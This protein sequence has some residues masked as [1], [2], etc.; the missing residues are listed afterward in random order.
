MNQTTYS[1]T[2]EFDKLNPAQKQAV[3]TI[4]GAVLVIAGPGTGKTQILAARIANILHDEK[5]QAKPENILC[6]TFTDAGVVAMRNRL[7]KFIGSEAH[8]V[9]IHTFHSFCNRVIQENSEYFGVKDVEPIMELDQ[10]KLLEELVDGFDK[11]HPLK[12]WRGDIYYDVKAGRLQKLFSLMRKENLSPEKIEAS[13]NEFIEDIPNKEEFLY[14][15]KTG[16]FEKGDVNP[17]KAEEIIQ[18]LRSTVAAAKELTNYQELKKKKGYYDFDDMIYWVLESFKS[19]EELLMSYQERFQY[20]LVD[21]YQD[22]NGAQN[23]IFKLLI[24]FWENPNAFVVGDDDQSIYRFQGANLGNIVDFYDSFIVKA[25]P[26][27][28]E[29]KKRVIV[30]SNNYRSTQAVLDL[31]KASIEHNNERL[32]H[33]LKELVLDKNLRASL[34]DRIKSKVQP[35]L[36]QYYNHTHELSDIAKQIETLHKEGA[37]LNEIAVIYR[38]HKQSEELLTFLNQKDIAVRTKRKLNILDLPLTS[39]LLEIMRY[40]AEESR[41]PHSR[42]DLLFQMFHFD[43]FELHSLQVARLAFELRENRYKNPK[44]TWRE[45]LHNGITVLDQ[46]SLDKLHRW[47]KVIEKWQSDLQNLPLQLFFQT[48]IDDLDLLPYIMQ[49][50]EKIWLLQELKTLFDF[51]KGQNNMYPKLKAIEFLDTIKTMQDYGISIDFV[52][53]T[54]A[55]NAVNFTT[56]HGSKGLEFKHVFLLGMNKKVWDS[57]LRNR[58]FKLPDGLLQDVSEDS[59]TEETRRLFYVAMTRAEEHLQISYAQSSDEGKDLS[60]SRYVSELIDSG[61][62]K[63]EE[64]HIGDKEIT[65]FTLNQIRLPLPLN[66]P[67]LEKA[68]FKERLEQ[69]SMS[70]THLNNYLK[71]PLK[72]YYTN[73]LQVPSAKNEHMA[74]GSAIHNA[75]EEMY[76]MM[77]ENDGVFPPVDTLIDLAERKLYGQEDSFTEKQ[78]GQKKDYIKEFLPKY[79]ATYIDTWNKNVKLEKRLYGTFNSIELNGALDKIEFSDNQVTIIDYK[80]GQFKNSVKKFGPP[81]VDLKEGVKLTY[82][83]EFGGDYWRQAVFYKILIDHNKDIGQ[84]HWEYDKTEFD[85]VEPDASTGKFN[86]QKV[87][88]AETDI[89]IVKDQIQQTFNNIQELKFDGCGEDDCEW[90]NL[91][92]ES[93]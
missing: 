16:K 44:I 79:Y 61:L 30:M 25:F 28:N 53:S 36:V 26:D 33:Q 63:L 70:V 17:R 93:K 77:L 4:D 86:K 21:E 42:E 51:I 59:D 1:F 9:N 75:L 15:R 50:E 80:T 19:K 38:I 78:Y 91:V 13:V 62:I 60:P 89:Q 7:I 65:E 27:I 73:F 3:E 45:V 5:T 6:L 41:I 18:R 84:Q 66:V 49:H 34:T 37:D 43:F 32:I 12:R 67:L 92:D 40:V 39:Q 55:E 11:N 88:V 58:D 64:E 87:V 52:K 56:A 68:Y 48:I 2:D 29:R 35:K 85:F 47:S 46:E 14:K 24:S 22:T 72:F 57:A 8:K 20:V 10:I 83:K 74:F 23:E 69:Y 76:K 71:C 31:S 90:C 81:A 54:Y 82:E